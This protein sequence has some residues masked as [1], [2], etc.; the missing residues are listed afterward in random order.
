MNLEEYLNRLSGGET[1]EGGS[2]M[3][4]F[5]HEVS[6]EALK[7]TAELNGSYHTPEQIREIMSR[8]TGREVDSTFGLF[9]PFY[10]DCGKNIKIGKNVFINA[11]CK[12]QDQGGIEIGDGALIGH[13]VVLA[14]LNHDFAPEN[15]STLH[16]SPIKIGKNVWIG[17]NATVL[18]GVNIGDGAIVAAGAV[19]TGDIPA[20][21]IAAGVPA[22]VIRK[23]D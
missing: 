9:P 5:M 16:P 17:A 21:T 7:I 14:T 10:T 18:P 6:Q 20:K 13:G 2:E 4:V 23:I 1:V 11:G 19:V 22:K 15:R 12:F 8:L 3:H